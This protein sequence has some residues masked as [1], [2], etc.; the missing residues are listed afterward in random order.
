MNSSRLKENQNI[1]N[2]FTVT[3]ACLFLWV[4]FF[5]FFG[6]PLIKSVYEGRS[7]ECFNRSIVG[8]NIFSIE[9]YYN[10]GGMIS[11]IAVAFVFFLILYIFFSRRSK[12]E[13][14]VI[15]SRKRIFLLSLAFIASVV[16]L[17]TTANVIRRLVAPGM[18]EYWP[19]S[20]FYPRFPDLH[21]FFFAIAIII[22]FSFLMKYL[23]TIESH[24][25]LISIIGILLVL[26]TNLTQGFPYGLE[27]PIIG[28][29]KGGIQYYHEIL[30]IVDLPYFLYYFEAL[31]PDMLLHSAVHPPGATLV[32]YALLRLLKEPVVVSIALMILAVPLTVYFF[33]NLIKREFGNEIAGYISL[34]LILLP[35]V[36]IHYLA[37]IDSLILGI[38]IGTLYFFL[39]RTILVS[40]I[41]GVILLFIFSFLTFAFLFFLPV[42]FGFEILRMKSVKRSFII[43]LA[44]VLIYFVIYYLIGF[45]YINSFYIASAIE[46][47]EGFRLTASPLYYILTRIE[48][49]AE[50]AVF[51][52]PF[53]LVLMFLGF[54]IMRSRHSRFFYLVIL[55]FITLMA[56]FLTGAYRTG[57]TARLCMY[58]YPYMLFPVIIYLKET[59]VK[60]SEKIK[61]M[62]LVF[63]QSL[64]MQ[65]FGDYF[66]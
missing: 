43:M 37:T 25:W 21:Y 18:P 17:N 38:S 7:L 13:E 66:Y 16:F 62:G 5:T 42:M 47:P 64:F 52:G 31:Q 39:H 19:I 24:P 28:G 48:N 56:M 2:F 51:F 22:F 12:N 58:I 41:G 9:H 44:L 6:K 55:S 50:I 35:T 11:F 46:N 4:F 59:H 23:S 60:Q 45:N 1:I 3:A 54:P 29:G 33:Y 14:N 15:F 32:I 20:Q 65:L 61:L 27:N 63:A 8:Q 36:Q 57:E 10:V 40:I 49:I 26:A 53:L 34:L 30:K